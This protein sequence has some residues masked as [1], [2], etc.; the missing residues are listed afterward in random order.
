MY[1]IIQYIKFLV[2]S[3]N[4]HG[5]HSPFIYKLVT[6]CFYDKK[7]HDEY[8]TLKSIRQRLYANK[9]I[10][11]V[12][13]YGAGSKVFANSERQIRKVAKIA[14]ITRKRAQLLFRLTK[15]FEP[16][17]ILE[18]GTSLGMGTSAMSLGN[19]F[20]KVITIEGC[21]ETSEVALEQFNHFQLKNIHL[22]NSEFDEAL[23][24]TEIK[25]SKFDLVYLDGNHNKE[26]TLH[27]FNEILTNI[28][29][30]TIM[31]FDDIHWSKGMTVAWETIK[32]HPQVKVT[33]DTFF[34]GIIFFKKRQEKEHFS[35][36]L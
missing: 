30:E 20:A 12:K 5:V 7:D 29:N 16:N 11:S 19:K 2:R 9:S 35:I 22:I 10:I 23:N 33:I 31:I 15:Y 24:S 8:S 17:N 4:Q 26:A 34:W 1:P 3:R 14:G 32:Q 6:E 13:D 36:R 28:S 21:K 18:L 25:D 27:Y